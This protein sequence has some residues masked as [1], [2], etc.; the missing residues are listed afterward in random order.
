MR[1][2]KFKISVLIFLGLG[3]TVLRAQEAIPTTG[4]NA[5]GSGGT[6]SY[7][8]GQVVSSTYTGA[9]GAVFQ[10]VQQPFE[11]LVVTGI[12]QANG[13]TLQ[14]SAFPNPTTDFLYLKV[15]G[16]AALITESMSY[17]LCDIQGKLLESKNLQETDAS[18]S[19]EKLTPAIYF[20]SIIA[21]QKV[22]KTF[23]IIKN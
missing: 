3:L 10:G 13:I 11:I 4:G 21:D 1:H 22:V 7:S 19:M 6:V 16:A 9:T 5:S 12:E 23:K 8:I 15:D 17:Q 20:L 2:K 18:I 14:C